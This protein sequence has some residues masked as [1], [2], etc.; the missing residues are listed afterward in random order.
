MS[1]QQTAT[2]KISLHFPVFTEWTP[3]QEGYFIIVLLIPY[4]KRFRIC[5]LKLEKEVSNVIALKA[6]VQ[7]RT[8][9][10]LPKSIAV[11]LFV[12]CLQLKL[13]CF[14]RP[15]KK[16]GRKTGIDGYHAFE[17]ALQSAPTESAGERK[18]EC[19][20][21]KNPMQWHCSELLLVITHRAGRRSAQFVFIYCVVFGAGAYLKIAEQKNIGQISV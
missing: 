3:D 8:H 5:A 9:S 4:Q 21:R 12:K 15:K 10:T 16:M 2:K 20:L 1:F 17:T 13:A 14:L 7:A 11:S 18:P 6:M 19:A